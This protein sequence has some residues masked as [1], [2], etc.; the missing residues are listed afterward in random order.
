[1]KQEV[2]F[3]CAKGRPITHRFGGAR[4]AR[5]EATSLDGLSRPSALPAMTHVELILMYF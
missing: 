2:T 3:S 5:F 1:M 4:E